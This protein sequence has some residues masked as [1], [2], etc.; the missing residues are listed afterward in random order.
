MTNPSVQIYG[1]LEVID[2]NNIRIQPFDDIFIVSTTPK[3]TCGRP[4]IHIATN[5]TKIVLGN[6]E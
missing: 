6:E 4:P 1:F 5:S 3:E 2:I